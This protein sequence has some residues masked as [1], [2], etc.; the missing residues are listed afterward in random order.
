MPGLEYDNSILP[1][2]KS[3][4]IVCPGLGAGVLSWASVEMRKK[5][6]I[7]LNTIF[8]IFYIFSGK[9]RYGNYNFEC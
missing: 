8:F 7:R 1:I 3:C 5:K 9:Q 4:L 2:P 6:A